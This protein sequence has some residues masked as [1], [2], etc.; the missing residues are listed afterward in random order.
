ML[1][2]FLYLSSKIVRKFSGNGVVGVCL[3]VEGVEGSDRV[4]GIAKHLSD[5]ISEGSFTKFG[6]PWV[7]GCVIQCGTRCV[8]V[9]GLK[10]FSRTFSDVGLILNNPM[11]SL[12]C[13]VVKMFVMVGDYFELCYLNGLQDLGMVIRAY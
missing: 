13:F 6:S 2:L 3:V 1:K 7:K 12:E 11:V 8:E 5:E 9:G 10:R 4:S